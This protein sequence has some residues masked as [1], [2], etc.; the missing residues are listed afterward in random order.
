MHRAASNASTMPVRDRYMDLKERETHFEFGAN[1]LSF[2]DKLSE[3]RVAQAVQGMRGM[4]SDRELAGARFLDIG[5]GSGLS[6]LA[7]LRM[8]A[9]EVVGVDVDENSVE[10]SR[11]C[12]SRFADKKKWQVS[13]ASVF[14]IDPEILGHFDVVHSWGVLHHTGDMRVAIRRAG[15]MVGEGGLL[16]IALYRKTPYCG[17][18]RAEKAIYSRMPAVVQAPTRWLYQAAWIIRS[19]TLL[20][21]PVSRIKA[22]KRNRGM[23]WTHDV[24]DWLGGYPYE[25][26][27]PQ[28]VHEMISD[29]GLRFVRENIPAV[30]GSGLFGSGCFEYVARR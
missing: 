26:V 22:Y 5:C 13:H 28:E 2:L 10:A 21:N 15:A 14:D 4:L 24:H 19:L 6:M 23:S 16:A 27:T 7:A 17:F 29:L 20:E 3:D 30:Y 9:R 8:G 18:W 1:W 12:L 11:A 25:S